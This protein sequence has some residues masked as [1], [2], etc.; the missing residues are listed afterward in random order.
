MKFIH[1]KT[2]LKNNALTSFK[3]QIFEN[4]LYLPVET[5]AKFDFETGE[6]KNPNPKQGAIRNPRK[7]LCKSN[8]KIIKST[9]V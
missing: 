6:E 7:E 3:Y 5:T 1:S 9:K 2:N 4:N 8:I